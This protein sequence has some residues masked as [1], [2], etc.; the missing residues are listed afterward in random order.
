MLSPK[1]YPISK[2]LESVSQ[3]LKSDRAV[4][5]RLAEAAVSYDPGSIDSDDDEAFEDMKLFKQISDFASEELQNDA[6]FLYELFFIQIKHLDMIGHQWQS[7]MNLEWDLKDRGLLV[8]PEHR[9]FIM[10]VNSLPRAKKVGEELVS[11]PW[12]E[13]RFPRKIIYAPRLVEG[14]FENDKEFLLTFANHIDILELASDSLNQDKEFVLACVS[15]YGLG[16][17]DLVGGLSN[18]RDVVWT[19]LFGPK[20]FEEKARRSGGFPFGKDVGNMNAMMYAGKKIKKDKEFLF[21]VL[22]ELERRNFIDRDM[23]DAPYEELKAMYFGHPKILFR[24]EQGKYNEYDTSTDDRHVN[25]YYINNW[26]E[27]TYKGK[28][29]RR[30]S[31]GG[32]IQVHYRDFVRSMLTEKLAVLNGA[33]NPR[34][35]QRTNLQI[36]LRF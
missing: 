6:E 10:R 33:S 35:R 16:L 3:E 18:D 27:Y 29:S 15:H 5:L 17:R 2:V 11:D 36:N 26:W 4:L 25:V 12:L 31:E 13:F 7:N 20:E 22:M 1:T 8:Y 30:K 21:C 9:E 32:Y 28:F 19:A 23:W 34:K 24:G 14:E